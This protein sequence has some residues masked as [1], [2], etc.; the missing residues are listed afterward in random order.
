MKR[1]AACL[2]AGL[3]VSL[4]WP[5]A[6]TA[7]ETTPLPAFEFWLHCSENSV[8]QTQGEIE[9]IQ[10]LHAFAREHDAQ[11]VWL[12]AVV[13]ADSG[14]GGCSRDVATHPDQPEAGERG[15]IRFE[16]CT[17][18][19]PPM[20]CGPRDDHVQILALGEPLAYSHSVFLPRED[21]LPTGLPYRF[22]GYSDWL[23]YQGPFIVR[24]FEGTG[25]AYA[26]FTVPDANLPRVW[27]RAACNR[28]P[29]AC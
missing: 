11:V 20:A 15:R 24:F 28:R 14:A 5:G 2:M 10:A 29:D 3:T 1:L 4:G 7:Q 19:N 21:A 26:T 23:N 27:D 9:A 22:G 16:P 13:G 8:E 25:Y 12:D 17:E 18:T 6:A